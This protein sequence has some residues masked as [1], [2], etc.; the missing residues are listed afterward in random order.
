[1]MKKIYLAIPYSGM[2]PSS[3]F[4]ATRATAM[5]LKTGY[6]VFSPITHSHPFVDYNMPQNWEFWEKID[7]Q[8]IDW[9]D[10]VI[11]L[12]PMEG[13]EVVNKS[14]GVQAEI[15]YAEEHGKLVVFKTFKMIVDELKKKIDDNRD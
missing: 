15:K 1:M 10:E 6:N 14:T 8:F 4:Q 13:H 7:Y 5:L 12:I 9:A 2:A 11:V 3:Y